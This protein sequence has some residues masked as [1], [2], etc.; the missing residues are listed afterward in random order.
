M[1]VIELSMTSFAGPRITVTEDEKEVLSFRANEDITKNTIDKVKEVIANA[2][3]GRGN[4]CIV[5]DGID[6]DW[7]Q[8]RLIIAQ[9]G[10]D[11]Y[12][13]AVSFDINKM[14]NDHCYASLGGFHII[15]GETEITFNQSSG[16]W[17]EVK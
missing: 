4:S 9:N 16:E 5:L 12:I 15:D 6:P 13:S 11:L 7:D 14:T 10:D 2:I 17:E 8:E 1:R 3:T